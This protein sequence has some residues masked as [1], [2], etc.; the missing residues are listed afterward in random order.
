M[1]DTEPTVGIIQGADKE[2]FIDLFLEQADHSLKLFKLAQVP[3]SIEVRLPGTIATVVKTLG[4][5]VTVT[6]F[7]PDGAKLKI[8]LDET[9]TGNLK[10]SEDL[11]D[12]E[13]K[14]V[15]AIPVA[16]ST[17]IFQLKERLLVEPQLFP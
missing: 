17:T 6:E 9:D 16:G 2:F 12:I 7:T 1:S 13:V 3:T 4:V 5:G 10:V 15:Q 11:Q 8:I 14:V